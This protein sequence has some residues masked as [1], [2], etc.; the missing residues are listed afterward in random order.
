MIANIPTPCAQGREMVEPVSG[1]VSDLKGHDP[2]PAA[3][4][5]M[6]K[7][8]DPK[9]EACRT[10]GVVAVNFH[11]GFDPSLLSD[12]ELRS[13]LKGSRSARYTNQLLRFVHKIA[14]GDRV[15][16]KEGDRWFAGSVASGYRYDPRVIDGHPHVRSVRWQNTPLGPAEA[17]AIENARRSRYATVELLEG[18]VLLDAGR[19]SGDPVAELSEFPAPSRHLGQ[20][21]TAGRPRWPAFDDGPRESCQRSLRLCRPATHTRYRHTATLLDDPSK[22][23]PAILVIGLNPSCPDDPDQ[24][25]FRPARQVGQVL[26][27]RWVGMINLLARRAPDLSQVAGDDLVGQSR[28]V[29]E[30]MLNQVDFTIAAWGLAPA[31]DTHSETTAVVEVERL[32]TLETLRRAGVPVLGIHGQSRHPSRWLQWVRSRVTDRAREGEHLAAALA[33]LGAST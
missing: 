2:A 13:T 5:W 21:R 32:W 12:D 23:G 3:R 7:T 11:V 17:M 6:V 16:T 33:P 22:A 24:P 19:P 31:S 29:L 15:V 25:T 10:A 20:I 18:S 8:T 1:P 28:E 14:I 4:T 9:L 26:G 27:A 30:A